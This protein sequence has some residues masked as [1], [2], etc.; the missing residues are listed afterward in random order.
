MCYLI[1]KDVNSH[2]CY[3]LQTKLGQHLVQLK[4]DLDNIVAD[5]GIQLVTISRPSAFGEYAPYH[6][7]EKES[8]F[9][10]LVTNMKAQP[11]QLQEKI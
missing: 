10:A 5:H 3:A 2:G 4:E 8:E 11:H 6:I 1:A 7:I 9:I